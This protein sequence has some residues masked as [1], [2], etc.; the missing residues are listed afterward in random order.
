MFRLLP[1]Q[2]VLAAVGTVNGIVSSYFASRY[3]GLD[4]MSAVG[5]YGPLSTFLGAVGT[6][7]TGGSAVICGRYLG[8]NR[9]DRLQ[10]VFSFDL[11]LAVCT[12]LV[13]TALFAFAGVFQLTGLITGDAVLRPIFSRYLLGQAAGILPMILSGQLPAFL[14][15]E[16]RS[17]RT[18]A[19]SLIY[20]AV[21]LVLNYVFVQILRMEEFGLA[22]A[23]SLG[24]WVFLAVQAQYFLSKESHLKLRPGRFMKEEC[25]EIFSVGLPGAATYLYLTVR[26]LAVNRLI[27]TYCGSPG[28]S[29]FA[30]ANSILG[31]FWAFSGGMQS[32]SRLLISVSTGEEDRQTLTDIMRVL[33]TGYVP[34]MCAVVAGIILSAPFLAGLYFPDRLQPVFDMTVAGLRIMPLCMPFSIIANHFVCWRQAAGRQKFVHIMSL[35]DGLLDVWAF[36]ALL[37]PAL[38]L[39]AVYIANVLNGLVTT[40]YIVLYAWVC[41]GHMPRNMEELMAMPENLGVPAEDRI[42]ISVRTDEEVVTVAERIQMFCLE[43]GIDRKRAYLAA[44]AMEEMAGNVVDHGFAKDSRKHSVDVR[45]AYRDGSVILR[46]RDDCVPFDPKERAALFDENDPAKNIGVRMICRMTDN[47]SYQNLLGLNVLTIRI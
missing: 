18:F 8:Q 1:A 3:V 7:I 44:L 39:N 12:G 27:E 33:F 5:L 2:V 4:A 21:N 9:N 20:I 45:A 36:T 10:D 16:N 32:V 11:T 23:S 29:A 42:D 46:I 19:A 6:L 43:K 26:G 31:L 17:R 35:L 47:I 37:I 28:L 34:L 40:L 38:G 13:F 24:M 14:A 30:V 15:M 25:L 41:A 22:L